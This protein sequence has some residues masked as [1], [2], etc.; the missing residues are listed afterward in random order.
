MDIATVRSFEAAGEAQVAPQG[1]D[2]A[3]LF[4]R[5]EPNIPMNESGKKRSFHDTQ[6]IAVGLHGHH[7][8]SV[9]MMQTPASQTLRLNILRQTALYV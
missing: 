1:R 2:R 8:M 5:L 7:A 4:H 9:V 6:V 3:E